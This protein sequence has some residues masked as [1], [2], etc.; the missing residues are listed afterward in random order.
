MKTIPLTQGKEAIVDDDMQ[1]FLSQWKWCSHGRGYACKGFPKENKLVFM[2]HVVSGQPLHGKVV[3]HINRNTFDN[4]RENLRHVSE[5]ENSYNTGVKKTS[6]FIGV[7][8]EKTHKRWRASI[9]IGKQKIKLGR[10]RE[11]EDAATVYQ[12]SLP[13]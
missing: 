3:D 6:R 9:R 2:H 7:S 4:R 1:E 8:W 11:E 12:L 13:R 5:R 10:F